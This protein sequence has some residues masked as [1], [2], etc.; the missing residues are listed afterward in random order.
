MGIYKKLKKA[1]GNHF[2]DLFSQLMKEKHG[3]GYQ[4][5]STYGNKGDMS[6]DGVLD[7]SIAFAVYAPETYNDSKAMEKLRSDFN[8]FIAQRANGNWQG[9]QKYIFV[10]KRK[11]KGITPSVMNLIA[12]FGQR[13]P[14]GIVT[15]DDLKKWADG[16]LP[17]SEDGKRLVE[18][19]NDVTKIMEYIIE[20]DFAAE[21]FWSLLSDNIEE[22]ILRKWNKKQYSFNAEN[23][24]NLRERILS[25]LRELCPYLDYPYVRALSDGRLLFDNTSYEAGERLRDDMQPNV[26]RIRC[27]VRD[28]LNELYTYK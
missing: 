25:A 16:F 15:M 13:F 9:I 5:T 24:E 8:G 21:P 23:L 18:F 28:L 26:Y 11:R 3:M 22:G 6:V 14:V 27:L 1:Y 12:E 7:S 20:T 2:Q 19:K 10:I 4:S 17:F